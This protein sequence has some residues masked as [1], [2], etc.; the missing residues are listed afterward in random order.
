MDWALF[1]G[2]LAIAIA[3]FFGLYGFRKDVSNKLSDIRDKLITMG[4][5]L[6]NAWELIRLRFVGA[7]GTVER[8]LKNLGKTTISAEPDVKST[9]YLIKVEKPVLKGGLIDKLSKNTKFEDIE[10]KMFNEKITGIHVFLPNQMRVE[11]PSIDPKICTEYISLFLKWLDTT[12]FNLLYK[13]K[14]YEEPIQI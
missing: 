4:V 13:I 6:E 10:K 3:I 11:V 9:I 1:S 7:S 8:N 12:Y 2:L 14:D 5:T